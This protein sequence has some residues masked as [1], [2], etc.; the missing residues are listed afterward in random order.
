M[1][2]W[3]LNLIGLC[4]CLFVFMGVLEAFVICSIMVFVF[5]FVLVVG[6]QKMETGLSGLFL[7]CVMLRDAV[8]LTVHD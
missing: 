5:V 2:A 8:F 4:L 3:G 7:F 6:D 1:M